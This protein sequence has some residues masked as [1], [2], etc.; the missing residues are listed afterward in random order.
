MLTTKVI[1]GAS[2]KLLFTHHFPQILWIK[3]MG[4][5]LGLSIGKGTTF[6]DINVF[7]GPKKYVDP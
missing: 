2:A 6:F 5:G 4:I 3:V 7:P 1:V